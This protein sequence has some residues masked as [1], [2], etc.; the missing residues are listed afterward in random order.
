MGAALAERL[1]VSGDDIKVEALVAAAL[2]AFDA[3]V[4]RW[5]E[6]DGALDLLGLIDAAFAA[7]A[8]PFPRLGD[9]D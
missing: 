2:G 9:H 7:V 3:A 6:S 1:G 8:A 5:S 4:N